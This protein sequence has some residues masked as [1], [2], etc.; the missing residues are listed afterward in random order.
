[1][2]IDKYLSKSAPSMSEDTNNHQMSPIESSN[3]HNKNSNP[4]LYNLLQ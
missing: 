2:K 1:M 3:K 4:A